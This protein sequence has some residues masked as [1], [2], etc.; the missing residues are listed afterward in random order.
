MTANSSARLP[1]G[2]R[3]PCPGEHT[4]CLSCVSEYIKR[5]LDPSGTDET[6]TNITVFP[7]PCPECPITIWESGIQDD[8]A[9][10]VFDAKS[11]SAWV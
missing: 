4:Y 6:N 5:K 9:E 11:M 2:L 1:F 8:V 7:I 3:L 10:R